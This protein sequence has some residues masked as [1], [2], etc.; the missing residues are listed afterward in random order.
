MKL[1]QR[2]PG[3]VCLQQASGAVGA[4]AEQECMCAALLNMAA[5][6]GRLRVAAAV[7]CCYVLC[8]GRR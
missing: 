4:T 8:A 7:G 6:G 2:Q 3:E 1:W 5:L